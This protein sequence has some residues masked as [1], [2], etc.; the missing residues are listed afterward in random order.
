VRPWVARLGHHA[1]PPLTVIVV[2][3][4]VA[5]DFHVH[6]WWQ[7]LRLLPAAVVIT[8]LAASYVHDR[9]LCGQCIA[10][11]PLDVQAQ[12]DA[13]V[14]TLRLAHRL[15]HPL[16]NSAFYAVLGVLALSEWYWQPHI[17]R[18]QWSQFS[19]TFALWVI[20]VHRAE[21]IHSR[22]QVACP[23]CHWG[24]GHGGDDSDG[25][26][27]PPDPHTVTDQPPAP[28]TRP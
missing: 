16:T 25:A 26:P 17:G 11:F 4:A 23:F 6:G 10:R 24:R 13:K 2:A 15:D 21:S 5:P 8:L 28:T 3:F 12:A 1:K 14:G 19:I 9:G 27:E 20:V 18:W 22:L 7:V